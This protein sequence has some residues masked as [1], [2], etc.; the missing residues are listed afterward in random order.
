MAHILCNNFNI[1]KLKYSEAAPNDMMQAMLVSFPNYDNHPFIF[2]TGEIYVTY[3][4]IPKI[5]TFYPTDDARSFIKVPL[6]EEQANCLE[7]NDMLTKIQ[8]Q[9]ENNHKNLL[10]NHLN[11]TVKST[12]KSINII[13]EK[14]N[15]IDDDLDKKPTK[16]NQSKR[17]CVFKFKKAHDTGNITTKVFLNKDD[18]IKPINV[19]NVTDIE[20]YLTWGSTIRMIVQMDKAWFA[21]TKKNPQAQFRDCGLSFKILQLEI[22]PKKQHKT[23]KEVYNTYAFTKKNQDVDDN[24]ND[25]EEGMEIEI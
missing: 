20:Q 11:Q 25:E 10:P 1:N 8:T 24:A 6:D 9:F 16:P 23:L 7:L 4:G 17:H 21:K 14:L 3:E 13:K 12:Y 15:D 22:T 18:T 2:E 19:T 5:G